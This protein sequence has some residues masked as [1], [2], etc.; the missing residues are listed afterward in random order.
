MN[1]HKY[2]DHLGITS[3]KLYVDQFGMEEVISIIITHIC[4]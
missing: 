4:Y 3:K 2:V 1:K